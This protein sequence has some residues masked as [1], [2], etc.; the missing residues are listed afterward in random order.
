[1]NFMTPAWDQALF[2]FIHHTLR[3]PAFDVL[4]PLISSP[5]LL[6]LLVIGGVAMGVRR[7]GKAQWIGLLLI[8]LAVG[9]ADGGTNIIK[10][11]TGRV[12]PLNALAETHFVEDGHWEQRAADFTP[13]KERG[14]SYPSAHA[15]NSMAA[16]ALVWL[17]WP[18]TRRTIWLL[19]FLV[20]LSRVYLGKH[21]PLDVGMGWLVGLAAAMTASILMRVARRGRPLGLPGDPKP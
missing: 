1:M 17:L 5:M 4:M 6:W 12:R 2:D 13:V 3:N 7:Y 18:G 21:Y 19:P 10:K 8:A 9:M 20:G 11:A 14:T 16:A 15:A